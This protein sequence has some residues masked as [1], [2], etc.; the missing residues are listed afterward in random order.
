MKQVPFNSDTY[1]LRFDQ[2]Y[3]LHNQDKKLVSCSSKNWE[4]FV[5]TGFTQEILSKSHFSK[6][7]QVLLTLTNW[8]KRK[9]FDGKQNSW[10]W[11]Q[12]SH[13]SHTCSKFHS[14]TSS[15]DLQSWKCTNEAWGVENMGLYCHY[16]RRETQRSPNKWFT[17]LRKHYRK[18]NPATINTPFQQPSLADG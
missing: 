18:F 14:N 4:K 1:F 9:I 3:V 10:I 7:L 2:K 5:K 15:L 16:R 6:L 8:L 13:F 11:F 17:T 12:S